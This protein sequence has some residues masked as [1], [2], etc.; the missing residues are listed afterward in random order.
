MHRLDNIR[1]MQENVVLITEINHLRKDINGIKQKEKAL[2]VG[3]KNNRRLST[4]S[5]ASKDGLPVVQHSNEP[6]R[7]NSARNSILDV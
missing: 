4:A 3:L 5:D 7:R 6:S 2:E 1:I